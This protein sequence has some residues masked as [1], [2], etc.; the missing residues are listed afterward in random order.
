MLA[1]HPNHDPGRAGVLR[2]IQASAVRTYEHLPRPRFV[3]MLKRLAGGGV[4]AGNS[5]SGLIQ[6]PRGLYLH[7]KLIALACVAVVA[8]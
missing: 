1:L 7:T 2:A 3:G 4:L 6:W 5:S 8:R